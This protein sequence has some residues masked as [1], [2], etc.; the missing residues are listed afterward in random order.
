M[1][2][3]PYYIIIS[4]CE[5]I[6]TLL[7]GHITILHDYIIIETDY[8]PWPASQP[9]SQPTSQPTSQ[10]ASQPSQPT[11]PAN[12]ANP[13]TQPPIRGLLTGFRRASKVTCFYAVFCMLNLLCFYVQIVKKGQRM[14]FR[15]A[16]TRGCGARGL[17]CV[18][19]RCNLHTLLRNA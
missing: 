7:Y 13:A 5:R 11:Q 6:I 1:I 18:C 12:P 17:F 4:P 8:H 14:T 2:T 10:P 19:F 15:R 16:K 3:S 9:A